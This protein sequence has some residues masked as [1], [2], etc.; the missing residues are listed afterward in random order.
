MVLDL[1]DKIAAF[2]IDSAYT[3]RQGWPATPLH[4]EPLNKGGVTGVQLC[5]EFCFIL[6]E[7]KGHSR[8]QQ[9]VL[10]RHGLNA[11]KPSHEMRS[12][13]IQL[14]K[15]K[16]AE[17]R[18]T[19]RRGMAREKTSSRVRVVVHPGMA[20]ERHSRLRERIASGLFCRDQNRRALIGKQVFRMPSKCGDQE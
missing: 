16:I 17:I 20:D 7:N 2:W 4:R 19:R 6:R 9:Y 15:R 3:P 18:I 11:A 14:E 8:I 1:P 5:H 12:G 10:T 13:D